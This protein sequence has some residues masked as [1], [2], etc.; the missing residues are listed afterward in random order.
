[1]LWMSFNYLSGG[2][3]KGKA[4]GNTYLY[5]YNIAFKL[6]WIETSLYSFNTYIAPSGNLLSLFYK[7]R[8]YANGEPQSIHVYNTGCYLSSYISVF[9]QVTLLNKH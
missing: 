1:M 6:Y 5:S 9:A 3:D 4:L 7:S 8:I 2:N